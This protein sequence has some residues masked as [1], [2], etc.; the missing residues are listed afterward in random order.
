MTAAP[1][2]SPPDPPVEGL[3]DAVLAKQ[4]PSGAFA[5]VMHDEDEQRP[6]DNGFVTAR[7]LGELGDLTSHPRLR[8]AVRRALDFLQSCAAEEL[9]GAYR[10]WPDSHRPTQVPRYPP[11]ADDTALITGQLARHGRL[12]RQDLRHTVAHLLVHHRVPPGRPPAPWVRAGAFWTWLDPRF[13]YNL[14]D[15]TVN[16]NVLTMICAAGLR[17]IAGYDAACGM[18]DLA[19]RIT[20]DEPLALRLVSPYYPQPRD[21]RDAVAR[22]VA[23]GAVELGPCLRL[24]RRRLGD[25]AEPDG[26]PVCSSAYGK[27]TW[28]AQ[29][30]RQLDGL[31]QGAHRAR[32]R[33]G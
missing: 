3:I 17:G 19:V 33:D 1:S 21:L 12:S 16:A 22:A 31:A 23:A 27:V 4:R 11:D 5:S 15:C 28:T 32:Q 9:P 29:L 25:A 8:P 18:I 2:G 14:V 30:L 24:L 26:A 6:D 10:F 7:V 20:K 13:A